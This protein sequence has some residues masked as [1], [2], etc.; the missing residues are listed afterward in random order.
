M[1]GSARVLVQRWHIDYEP[2]VGDCIEGHVHARG[3][4]GKL[5]AFS[6]TRVVKEDAP[7]ISGEDEVHR[8]LL[9][10]A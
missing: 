3:K 1:H 9:G 8:A 6:V 4:D 7:K 2:Q 10:L 5:Y